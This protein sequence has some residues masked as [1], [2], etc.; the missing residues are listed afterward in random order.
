MGGAWSVR[1]LS[2]TVHVF[3]MDAHPRLGL[4]ARLQA[5]CAGHCVDK[6][7][8]ESHALFLNWFPFRNIISEKFDRVPTDV[9]E[10][11]NQTVDA[12]NTIGDFVSVNGTAGKIEGYRIPFS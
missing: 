10:A 8:N 5:L 2:N 11:D 3:R 4:L 7:S 12:E 1:P 6:N 9:W